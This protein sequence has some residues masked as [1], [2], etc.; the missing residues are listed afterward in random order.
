MEKN[1]EKIQVGFKIRS[2]IEWEKL[3]KVSVCKRPIQMD[4]SF[5]LAFTD[6]NFGGNHTYPASLLYS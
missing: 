6:F 1:I 4:H 2:E 5:V 3:E